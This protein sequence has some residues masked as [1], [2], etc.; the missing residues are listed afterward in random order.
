LQIRIRNTDFN[1]HSVS[2]LSFS[3]CISSSKMHFK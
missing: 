3:L 2:R 1:C